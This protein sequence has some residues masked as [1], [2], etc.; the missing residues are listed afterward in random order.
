MIEARI[1]AVI[2]LDLKWGRGPAPA[3]SDVEVERLDPK[4]LHVRATGP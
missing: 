4:P 3:R 1:G 2:A